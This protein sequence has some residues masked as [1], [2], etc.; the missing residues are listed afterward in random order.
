MLIIN[1]IPSKATGYMTKGMIES[2]FK[3]H[4]GRTLQA[5]VNYSFLGV[6]MKHEFRLIFFHFYFR[7]NK[8]QLYKN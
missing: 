1:V 6:K 7:Q 5:L 3:W 8:I 2:E 4:E